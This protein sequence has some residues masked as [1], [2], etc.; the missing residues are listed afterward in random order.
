MSSFCRSDAQAD[1]RLP[2]FSLRNPSRQPALAQGSN[3]GGRNEEQNLVHGQLPAQELS[4]LP[5]KAVKGE[6]H[7]LIKNILNS[8]SHQWICG[9]FQ[10][11]RPM[12]FPVW[13]GTTPL[14][15][16]EFIGVGGVL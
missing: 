1:I 12:P 14:L 13:I 4:A 16:A 3:D 11:L 8:V 6:L 5:R 7:R 9:R 15:R 2:S 10:Q